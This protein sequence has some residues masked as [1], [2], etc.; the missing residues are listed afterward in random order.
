MSAHSINA[1]SSR[2]KWIAGVLVIVYA[3]ITMIPL[4]WIM[5]TGF[6]SPSD[7][8]SY[9]P[10]VLFEPTLEG[11]VNLFTTRTRQ[12]DEFLAANPPE[13]LVRRDRAPV[14][15]GHR[16]PVE[17]R[18]TFPELGHHRLRLDLPDRSSWARWPPMP[19]AGSRYPSPDDLL[20][21]HPLD[22]DD[23]AHCR[24]DPDLPDVSAARAVGH[25]SGH[26]PALYGGQHLA[27]GLAARRV[28]STRSRANTKKRR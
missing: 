2:Q 25:A 17:I 13:T 1:P 28:S 19:S 18:R 8:I 9:P 22:T 27:G 3:L 4:A 12:T 14:R 5:L 16:R 6:K 10:K 24:G 15:H 7:A 20:V 23:A 26:D 11:Y 21:L